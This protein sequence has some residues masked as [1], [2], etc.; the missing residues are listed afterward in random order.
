[1]QRLQHA[2]TIVLI[3]AVAAML[4]WVSGRYKWDADWTAGNRNS[5]T[6]A[7]KRVLDAMPG[8]IKFTAYAYPGP[9]RKDVRVQIERYQRY[10]DDISLRFVDPAKHPNEVRELGIRRD[11]TVR[12]AYK[13]RTETIHKLREQ[14]ITNTLQRLSV[15]GQQWAVFLSGHGER[16][17]QDD[18]GSGYSQL[19]QELDNQ[20][21]KVRGLNLAEAARIPDNTAV[22]VIASPQNNLLP[23]EV[24]MIRDY[25]DNG[26]NL[27]WLDDPGKRYGL[28]PLADDLGIEWQ[29]GTVIYPDYRQLG[30]GNPAIALVVDYAKHPVT[31]HLSSLTLFPYAGGLKAAQQP[32][33]GWRPTPIIK[34]PQRS[35]LETGS[36]KDQQ[37]AF[38]KNSGD[39]VG[40]I[41]IGMALSRKAPESKNAEA[42]KSEGKAG[43]N[44]GKDKA[45]GGTDE[46]NDKDERRQQRVAVI[47]DSDFLANAQIN[48]LGN[49]QL[50]VSLFQWLANRDKQ[51]SVR[52][53]P[54]PD[55]SLHLA[56]WQGRTIWYL[57]VIALPILL[58]ATGVGRWWL[59][60]RR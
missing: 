52:V 20:G 5:L 35:W 37:I 38:D 44:S 50:G 11:G 45:A 36:L 54:A 60:R 10:R 49:M 51:I 18:S 47:A 58:L 30:T 42:G 9:G 12:V 48:S 39:Q 31:E 29:K 7:S 21:L 24:Q 27:L 2:F 57:F 22:L 28:V 19:R 26:G 3:V 16:D 14:T 1:M 17:P 15:A 6:A 55:S 25:V 43:G 40:P 56:P 59:R 41:T 8:D 23:G 34:T 13:G 33:N 53:P 46:D 32:V 4:V